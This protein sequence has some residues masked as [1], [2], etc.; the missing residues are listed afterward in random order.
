MSS[1]HST[2]VHSPLSALHTPGAGHDSGVVRQSGRQILS[3]PRVTQT[4]P[5]AQGRSSLQ[6][7]P[8][9]PPPP[10]Q[11]P[12]LRSQVS[13]PAHPLPGSRQSAW[14]ILSPFRLGAQTSP[15]GQGLVGPQPPGGSVPPA[16]AVAPAPAAPPMP[17]MPPM[18]AVPPMPPLPAV[19]PIPPLPAMPDCASPL[20]LP[21]APAVP[22]SS[23]LAEFTSDWQPRLM[24]STQQRVNRGKWVS[25]MG[26][27]NLKM[28][29]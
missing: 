10:P 15:D 9:I 21:P 22:P 17:A 12:V 19:A 26:G 5:S 16:P 23:V 3:L 8:I 2:K 1:P 11:R 24:L 20:L 27:S 28:C 25:C 29:P 18:P 7:P 6:P 4:C 13:P 14:H